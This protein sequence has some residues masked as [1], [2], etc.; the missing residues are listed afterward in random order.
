MRPWASCESPFVVDHVAEAIERLAE[1]DDDSS[2]EPEELLRE[3]GDAT[4][5]RRLVVLDDV[6][7]LAFFLEEVVDERLGLEREQVVDG[8]RHEEDALR[9]AVLRG[10]RERLDARAREAELQLPL[11]AARS[12]A[13]AAREEEASGSRAR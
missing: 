7:R 2:V 11:D 9:L 1:A 6:P 12:R 4:Q 5:A 8:R 3:R 10:A 13:R